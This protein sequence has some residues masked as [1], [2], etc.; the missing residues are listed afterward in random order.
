M[1]ETEGLIP[2]PADVIGALEYEINRGGNSAAI[3]TMIEARDAL[4]EA[5]DALDPF[6]EVAEQDIGSDESN[7]DFFRPMNPRV[8]RAPAITVGDM[9]RA[10]AIRARSN[11]T[12]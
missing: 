1:N 9:R 12:Q 8:A 4:K 10:A 3:N 7:A 5:Y 2:R 11:P 6:A